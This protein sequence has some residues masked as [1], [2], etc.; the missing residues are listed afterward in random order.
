MCA[1]DL[2][3]AAG[4]TDGTVLVDVEAGQ[5]VDTGSPPASARY[6]QT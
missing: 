3:A 4:C 5:V 2:A 1:D 6:R